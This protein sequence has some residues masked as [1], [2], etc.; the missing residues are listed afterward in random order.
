MPCLDEGRI[1]KLLS[2]LDVLESLGHAKT[3]E[4][5]NSSRF[6]WFAKLY[7]N[8]NM[9]LDGCNIE[10]MFL[11]TS[12]VVAPKPEERN[13]HV[14]YQLLRGL[15]PGLKQALATQQV[16]SYDILHTGTQDVHGFNDGEEWQ[17]FLD[18]LFSVGMS[19]DDVVSGVT[20][21]LVAILD[22]GNLD[23]DSEGLIGDKEA[24]DAV[25][26]GLG[27]LNQADEF[28]QQLRGPELDPEHAAAY[29][30][31]SR[32]RLSKT[33]YAKVIPYTSNLSNPNPNTACYC[34]IVVRPCGGSVQP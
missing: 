9:V 32:D 18:S 20:A 28:E 15:D 24:R 13:F 4:N 16:A 8:G 7:F 26:D 31:H 14:F 23:F 21:L 19:D 30:S 3:L 11:E 10:T 5:E 34:L 6:G 25:C 17:S 29:S 22:I 27:I 2:S 33:L 1:D 12:R